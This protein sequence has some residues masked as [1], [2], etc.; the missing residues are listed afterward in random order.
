[1]L[2]SRHLWHLCFVSAAVVDRFY[3]ALLSALKQ[4]R[5]ARMGFYMSE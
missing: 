5:S 2:D 1:M 3:I 4:T